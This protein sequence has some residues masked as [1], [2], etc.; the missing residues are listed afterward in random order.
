MDAIDLR[1]L[2]ELQS[3]A[4][5]SHQDLAGRVGLS[6]SPCARRIHKLEADGIIEGYS[7]R[8]NE[9]KTGFGF[10]VFVSVRLDQQVDGR[11]AGFEKRIRECSEVIDCWL[12]TGSFDYLLR[13]AV[14]DLQEFETF[15]TGRL[16]KIP[17]VALIESSI[18]IRRVKNQ[19]GR[20]R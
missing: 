7:A 1:I 3:D 8:I 19:F 18:P 12:M 13:I 11:L 2:H 15:L 17:G 4:R 10:S 14:A 20:L 6:A 5:I 16:T 9:A